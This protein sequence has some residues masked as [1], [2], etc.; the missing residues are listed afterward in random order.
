MCGA[1]PACAARPMKRAVLPTRPLFDAGTPALPSSARQLVW[2]IIARSTSSKWPRRISSCLPHGNS[3]R[4]ARICSCRHSMSPPSSAGTPKKTTRPARCSNAP[5]SKR[6]IAAPSMPAICA[7]C[8]QACATPV[9][10]SASGCARSRAD[11]PARRS[12]RTSGRRPRARAPPRGPRSSRGRCAGS[13]PSRPRVSCTSPAVFASLKPI[14][15]CW[16]IRSPSATISVARRSIAANTRPFSSSLVMAADAS[17]FARARPGSVR[18][19]PGNA[20]SL[21]R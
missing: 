21:A 2:I 15:G 14:S 18:L 19:R 12:A 5:A 16:R 8:P 10:G 1:P 4:P 9:A 17:R 11:R 6:P 13:C 20:V 3:R 7:L